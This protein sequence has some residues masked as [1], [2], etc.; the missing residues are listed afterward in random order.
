MLVLVPARVRVRVCRETAV[1]DAV[2]IY[3]IFKYDSKRRVSS[4]VPLAVT[5][6]TSRARSA[7]YPRL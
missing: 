7:R 5:Y 2:I 1:A 4:L 3:L 6:V